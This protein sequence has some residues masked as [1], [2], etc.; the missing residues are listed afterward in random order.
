[1]MS[2]P[3]LLALAAVLWLLVLLAAVAVVLQLSP[4]LIGPDA[5]PHGALW[6]FG[7]LAFIG[8][9][10][11]LLIMDAILRRRLYRITESV[12]QVRTRA[13][14]G[15]RLHDE[16]PPEYRELNAEINGVL[17][18]LQR[19]HEAMQEMN[20]GLEKLV[21]ERTADVEASKIA[22][23]EDAARRIQGERANAERERI[24]RS[25]H[26]MSPSGILLLGEDGAILD[27]NHAYCDALGY[28]RDELLGRNVEILLEPE[29]RGRA[30][31]NIKRL[32]D[33]ET[34]E[35]IE[36]TPG[37][38]GRIHL[39]E[40]RERAIEL[41]DGQRRILVMANDVTARREK[42]EQLRLQ[43]AALD[44]AANGIMLVNREGIIVW[45]NEAF[46]QLTGYERHEAIGQSPRIM[47]SGRHDKVFYHQLWTTVLT[48]NMWRGELVNRRK[49]GTL[50][51]EELTITPVLD[52]RGNPT[53]FI[54]IKQ[55]ISER[56]HL[57][58][59]LLQAQKMET[60]G[61][62]AGGI[63]HDFNNLLQAITGFADILLQ[64]MD[65]ANPHRADV[66]EIN[67]AAD[68][69]TELTRQL[70]AFSRKQMLEPMAVD[71]NDLV[72]GTEKMLRRLIGEDIQLT[73]ELEPG[74]D[75]IQAD[76]GQLE[77]V[78]VNLTVN[79]RDAM[80]VGGR[81]TIRTNGIVLLKE[82]TLLDPEMRSGRFVMLSVTDSGHGMPPDV[83]ARIFEPFF[84][85]KGPGRGT[86]LGLSVV[87][88]IVQQH[89]GM[90]RV[91]SEPGQGTTFR[92]YL[93]VSEE[94]LAT[95]GTPVTPNSERLP[96]GRGE[97][98]LLVED[99]NGVR[100][101]A[102]SALRKFGYQP[103]AAENA[104]RAEELFALENGRFDLVFT[105]VVLP[106][107]NGLDLVA[108]LQERRPDIRILFTSGYMDEKSR[109]P[110]IR[111]RNYPFLQKPYPLARLL[112]AI[113]SAI[114]QPSA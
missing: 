36:R 79:A 54:A 105:D 53:H 65:P 107:Q 92:I 101:F 106:D 96:R 102:I 113:R 32:M 86:G 48:G 8:G 85:T 33:G 99:E 63:A 45:V 25:I 58:Q 111:D 69:A 50:Y 78:L 10:A 26:E 21:A 7:L 84:T 40:L 51:L 4:R 67:K 46:T 103:Y 42:E 112:H 60:I 71:L 28:A 82:D 2:R 77:Q 29:Q 89:G 64:D 1:M 14:F 43:G 22:L 75:L 20:T 61:Q 34:L 72:A 52:E 41:P 97:R 23:A 90:I 30:G 39:M 44:A 55:D 16:G 66:L 87:Y 91:Y 93:P 17:G 70:L 27:V 114:E 5:K 76:P 37:R 95:P 9:G 81:L 35:H 74:L 109:W 59:Q 18:T 68:R 19:I 83:A 12:R 80:G 47:K 38:D 11:G 88:G 62:L 6:Y 57:Q 108:I 104:A 15:A 13:D 24:Y 98:I 31:L 110:A 3:K 100:D 49:N 94:G 56:R 73:L